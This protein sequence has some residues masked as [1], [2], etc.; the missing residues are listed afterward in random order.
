MVKATKQTKKFASSG[1]LKQTIEKRRKYQAIQKK[2]S[3]RQATKARK[4]KN[5]KGRHADDASDEDGDEDEDVV[6][7]EGD[8]DEQDVRSKKGKGKEVLP[9]LTVSTVKFSQSGFS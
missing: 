9:S 1:K 4:E 3:G 6:G 8:D 5:G 2:V 7:G